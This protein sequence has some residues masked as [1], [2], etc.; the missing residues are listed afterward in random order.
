MPATLP[1][2]GCIG[3]VPP[4]EKLAALFCVFK[5]I[6]ESGG[7]GNVA[8][9]PDILW[10]KFL[11]GSGTDIGATVGTDGT[12]DA[13]WVTGKTGSGFALEFNGTSQNAE[14]SNTVTYGT[15]TI[16]LCAWFWFDVTTGTRMLL[17]SSATYI[18]PN[19][20]GIFVD[21]NLLYA[22]NT[23]ATGERQE[24][25]AFSTT[26]AWVHLAVVLTPTDNK[27]FVDGVEQATTITNN[28]RTG[29]ADYSA[30][31]L[32]VGARNS[33][34]LFFDG[35]IDDLRIYSGDVSADLALIMAAAA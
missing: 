20:F 2:C 21:A 9:T 4:S 14:T 29:T 22:S 6:A 35:R 32:F 10:W 17:E 25:I 1:S 12:T 15:N 26:G 19:C 24:Y 31:T 5:D 3:G 30:Q 23:G 33:G 27:I 11:E 13:S 34:S 16:T 28:N 18:T 7:G 8:P